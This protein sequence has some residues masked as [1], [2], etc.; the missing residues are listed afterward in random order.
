MFETWFR[1]VLG[2]ITSRS[3]ICWFDIPRAIS[4]R[5]SRSRSLSSGKAAVAAGA[6]GEVGHQATGDVRPEDRLARSDRPDGASRARPGRRPS[7][8]SRGHRPGGRRR[9]PRRRRP[10][11]GRGPRC[12]GSCRRSDASPRSRRDP[13]CSG[14]SARRRAGVRAPSS[15]AT[16]P[17]S[18]SPT[19]ARRPASRAAP[20]ARSGTPRDHRRR[21][22]GSARPSRPPRRVASR[23][24]A[25]ARRPASRR[26]AGLDPALPT[27]LGGPLV[28]RC[29]P[30]AR[31]RRTPGSPR[32]SSSTTTVR[33]VPPTSRTVQRAAP[34]WRTAF[35]I[36]S[37]PIR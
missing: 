37:V 33:S 32:P 19:S 1:T 31:P 23:R 10:S 26:P 5:T 9:R 12:A 24:V 4:S 30:D 25:T 18:A 17:A 27:E 29:Q 34:A 21:G 16:S 13:A 22:S 7:G 15:T 11:S 14:P 3:T 6:V 28:H 36:A 2:E 20:P 8:G 35:V